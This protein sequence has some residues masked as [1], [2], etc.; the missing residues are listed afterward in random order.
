MKLSIVIITWK[1]RQNLERCLTSI[2]ASKPLCDFEIIVV[3]NAS[4]DE[5][6]EMVKEKFPEVKLVLNTT[7]LGV[8][9]ARNQGVRQALGETIIFL[10]SDTEVQPNSMDTLVAFLDKNSK[11]TVV[12]PQLLNLDGSLQH[13]CRKFPTLYTIFL[14]TLLSKS[15]LV[16]E[17]LMLDWNHQDTREVDWMMAACIAI[18]KKDF[19]KIKG[20]DERYFYGYEEVDLQWRIRKNG[21]TIWYLPT[22]KVIHRYQKKSW[23]LNKFTLLHAISLFRFLINKH[24]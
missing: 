6:V 9:K 16:R 1:D 5:T 4:K 10:D 8:S 24:L 15:I 12:G 17:Y 19:E 2:R 3:D 18:R 14:R 11:A 21:G 23:K 13:S 7:N 20:F 22:I